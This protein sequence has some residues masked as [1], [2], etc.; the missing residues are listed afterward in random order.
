MRREESIW[1]TGVG[2]ATPLGMSL[3]TIAEALLSGRRCADSRMAGRTHN[4]FDC[5]ADYVYA[6]IPGSH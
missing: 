5:Y 4:P 2:A 6:E 1:I 3:P